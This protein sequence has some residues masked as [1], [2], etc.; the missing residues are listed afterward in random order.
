MIRFLK[1]F[2]VSMALI[3]TFPMTRYVWIL[4]AV[5]PDYSL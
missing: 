2:R 1:T 4:D 5:P 3:W